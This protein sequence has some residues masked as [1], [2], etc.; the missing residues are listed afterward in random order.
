MID[1]QNHFLHRSVLPATPI[2]NSNSSSKRDLITN[3]SL[4]FLCF[5]IRNDTVCNESNT[6]YEY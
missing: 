6:E 2:L 3:L 4:T 1:N 5:Q